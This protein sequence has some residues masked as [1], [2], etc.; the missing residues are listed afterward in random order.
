MQDKGSLSRS[1][2]RPRVP[3]I[4]EVV[5]QLYE[6]DA[7]GIPAAWVA[8]MRQSMAQLTP[9]YS[10]ARTVREYV[11]KY[12]LPAASRYRERA[13]AGGS[14]AKQICDWFAS[15]Q[16]SWSTLRFG[17]ISIETTA[18]QH[19]FEI[20]LHLSGLDPEAITVELFAE[21]IGGSGPERHRALR[22]SP[23]TGGEG[24]YL[25]RALVPAGRP[26]GDYSARAFP[27]REGVAVPLKAQQIL[28]QR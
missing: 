11:E 28:W 1:P 17:E 26:P 4:C 22:V 6:R 16:R 19:R 5:P 20:P 2:W 15:L 18:G 21:G 24:D 9:Q 27:C 8:R 3:A 25:Y 7:Q 14:A 23:H 12:Y 13:A 10:S